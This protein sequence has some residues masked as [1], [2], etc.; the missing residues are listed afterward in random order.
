MNKK[1]LSFHSQDNGENHENEIETVETAAERI[2]RKPEFDT[3][4]TGLN[5]Y[6]N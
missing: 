5:G 1:Q 4:G 3:F 2:E 6:G